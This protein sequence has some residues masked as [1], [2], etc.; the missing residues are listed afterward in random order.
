VAAEGPAPK[1]LMAPLLPIAG[2]P[3]AELDGGAPKALK[4]VPGCW[5]KAVGVCAEPALPAAVF[6]GAAVVP[7]PLPV[8]DEKRANMFCSLSAS[9][10]YA[11]IA[12]R[13]EE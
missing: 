1:G 7:K 3:K 5:P 6:P 4:A 2:A 12:R 9:R 8:D 13:G 10:F 11:Y